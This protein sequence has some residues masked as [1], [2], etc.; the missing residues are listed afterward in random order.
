MQII[1]H[2]GFP[3]ALKCDDGTISITY[4]HVNEKQ[5]ISK[6]GLEGGS[7]GE[8]PSMSRK[9]HSSLSNIPGSTH[10]STFNRFQ[11]QGILKPG[12]GGVWGGYPL[13]K[14]AGKG[15]IKER[16]PLRASDA[17]P[18]VTLY[19]RIHRLVERPLFWRIGNIQY[20]QC[21]WNWI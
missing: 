14:V 6:L 8:R 16:R 3:L 5:G 4:Q 18:R 2:L 13:A 19:I 21:G 12:S 20:D 17:A 10:Y 7:G 15:R 1:R 11:K 9:L